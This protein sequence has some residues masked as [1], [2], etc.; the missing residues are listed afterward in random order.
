MGY[1]LR[2]ARLNVSCT[3]YEDYGEWEESTA[4]FFAK[5]PR[6]GFGSAQARRASEGRVILAFASGLYAAESRAV[7]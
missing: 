5:S 6:A 1:P 2:E 4:L 7:T 3:L